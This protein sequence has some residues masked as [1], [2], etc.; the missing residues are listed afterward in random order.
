MVHAFNAPPLQIPDGKC[1]DINE[2]ESF[3][4][5]LQD[6]IQQQEAALAA[7]SSIERHNQFVDY[8][9]VLADCY[10]EQLRIF[11]ETELVRRQQ[12]HAAMVKVTMQSPH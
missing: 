8:L 1:A 2:M 12:L 7:V 4:N 5:I 3:G 10:N 9:N 11:K 6:F